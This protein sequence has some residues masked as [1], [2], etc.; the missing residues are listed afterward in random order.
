MKK[1]LYLGALVLLLL[2][3]M[4]CTLW[5]I[6]LPSATEENPATSETTSGAPSSGKLQITI[7]NVSPEDVC[8]VY[9]TPSEQENWG[10]DLLGNTLS[11]GDSETFDL[12]ASAIY[13]VEVDNCDDIAIATAWE[14]DAS[15][16]V[17]VGES[18]ATTRVTLENATDTDICY[19]YISLPTNEDWGGDQLGNMEQIPSGGLRMFFAKPGVYDML[20]S[21]CDDNTL[22]EEYEVDLSSDMTW[23]VQ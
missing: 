9:I 21:D 13:D 20:A 4:A 11:T 10:D 12:D 18:G 5:G 8:A 17:Q 7:K 19:F 15:T 14:I 16:T 22:L 1:G 3:T 6:E 2:A 23:T